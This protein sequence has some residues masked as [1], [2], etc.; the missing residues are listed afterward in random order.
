M[1]VDDRD[2]LEQRLF[3]SLQDTETW[4]S[5]EN[6]PRLE[7]F[8]QLVTE[9]KQQLRRDWQRELTV[10]LLVAICVVGGVI[11]LLTRTP[12]LFLSLQLV[13]IAFLIVPKLFWTFRERR[14][15]RQ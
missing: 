4:A 3:Q 14:A 12:V 8:E 5:A 2:Q 7:W 10:F 9:R 6:T 13:L 15:G 11:F 1:N